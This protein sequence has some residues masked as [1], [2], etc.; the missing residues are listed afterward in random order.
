MTVGDNVFAYAADQGAE[1]IMAR[2]IV[3]PLY[4]GV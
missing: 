4:E 3:T 1:Y 2:F